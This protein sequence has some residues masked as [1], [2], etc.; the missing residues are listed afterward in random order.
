MN[1]KS[2]AILSVSILILLCAFVTIVLAPSMFEQDGERAGFALLLFG[3]ASI[4]FDYF[5]SIRLS[6][7]RN[8]DF[9]QQILSKEYGGD[10]SQWPES[11]QV[12]K[13]DYFTLFLISFIGVGFCTYSLLLVKDEQYILTG[14]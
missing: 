13:K 5:S 10:R 7:A 14:R 4:A 8:S 6:G 3:M 1:R 12:S 2:A 9:G 11:L